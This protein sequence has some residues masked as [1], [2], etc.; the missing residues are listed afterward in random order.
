LA[1]ERA[2]QRD[3][4]EFAGG[5]LRKVR[6]S[7]RVD[8]V[9]GGSERGRVGTADTEAGTETAGAGERPVAAGHIGAGPGKEI[10]QG[11]AWRRRARRGDKPAAAV[12]LDA[13]LTHLA[14][15]RLLIRHR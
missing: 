2:A 14:A 7:E 1:I 9:D 12:R 10:G 15:A 8:G 11:H 5:V 4:P 13:E 3:D 6:G